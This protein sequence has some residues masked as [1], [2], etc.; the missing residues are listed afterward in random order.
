MA[1]RTTPGWNSV[2]KNSQILDGTAESLEVPLLQMPSR[3]QMVEL[4][5]AWFKV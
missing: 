3:C 2:G 4:K 1:T 5:P